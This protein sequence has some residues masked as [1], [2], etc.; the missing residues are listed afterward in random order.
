MKMEIYTA[1]N[2]K[3]N[4]LLL[5]ISHFFKLRLDEEHQDDITIN[6]PTSYPDDCLDELLYDGEENWV[7]ADIFEQIYKRF[8]EDPLFEKRCRN[9]QQVFVTYY[10]NS[11]YRFNGALSRV[12][13]I[14]GVLY[15]PYDYKAINRQVKLNQL[16]S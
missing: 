11:N 1:V 4:K 8:S 12:P 16:L 9:V 10:R 6:L 7:L 2:M 15:N 5:R 13:Y 3:I 14:D